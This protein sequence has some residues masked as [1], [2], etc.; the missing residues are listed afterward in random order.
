MSNNYDQKIQVSKNAIRDTEFILIGGGSGLSTAAGLTYSGKRFTENFSDFIEKYGFTDM[1]SA[2]FYPFETQEELWAHWARHIEINRFSQ[3]PTVLYQKLLNLV[4]NKEFFVI[5]TN[6][7]SQFEKS[8][9]PKEKIF[10]VQGNYAYLQCANGCHD[11]LY[12]NESL[13]KQMIEETIDCKIPSSLVPVCPVCGGKMDV[14]LRHDDHFVQDKAWYQAKEEYRKFIKKIKNQKTVFFE[15]G[16]GY[17][18]PGIIRYPFENMIYKNSKATLIRC[19]K[20]Y[21][22]GVE[23]NILHTISFIEDMNQVVDNLLEINNA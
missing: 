13:V 5:T 11:E 15:L 20:D 23:G 16:V 2:S 10:E 3:S 17:N 22:Q 18:T 9:F 21:P 12:F 4:K 6:V 14:N 1:Y 7:E 8:G 19:N